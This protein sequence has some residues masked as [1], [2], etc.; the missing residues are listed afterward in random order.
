MKR[1]TTIQG[2]FGAVLLLMVPAATAYGGDINLNKMMTEKGDSL[3]TVKFVL[4]ISMGQMFGGDQESETEITGVMI[5]PKGLV[6]CS[7]TQLGGFIGMMKSMMGSMGSQMSATPSDLKVLIGDDTE[8]RDADL[9]A[10]DT[11]LDLAWIRIKTPGDKPFAYV[12]FA[13]AGKAAVGDDVFVL[14]RLGKYFARTAVI[15]E[16]RIGGV[17]QKPRE[18][19]LPSTPLSSSLGA[20]VFAADGQPAGIIVMQ[21][22]DSDG[23]TDNPMAMMGRMSGLQDMMSGFILPAATIVKATERALATAGTGESK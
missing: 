19:M 16:C 6:I 7:N 5:E 8:G 3:V 2:K 12:D 18:L 13:K 11:E 15:S 4:K 21:M 22:P 20:P 14:R 23:S 9:V 10:R 17:T 1:I